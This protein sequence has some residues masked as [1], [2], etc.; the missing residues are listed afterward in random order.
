M[1]KR[2][3]NYRGT[4]IEQKLNKTLN[5]D[6]VFHVYFLNI[7]FTFHLTFHCLNIMKM[8][9]DNETEGR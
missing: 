9:F 3:Q 2:K 7:I 8:D 1:M 6:C 5:P 4:E